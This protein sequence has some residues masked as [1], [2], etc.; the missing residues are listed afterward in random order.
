MVRALAILGLK[1]H[2]VAGVYEDSIF[3]VDVELESKRQVGTINRY[4]L[5]GS[6]KIQRKI[7]VSRNIFVIANGK[8]RKNPQGCGKV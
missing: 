3:F 2:G 8:R 7:W 4:D 5:G 1:V 6:L